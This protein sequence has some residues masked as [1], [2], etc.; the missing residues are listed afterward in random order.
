MIRVEQEPEPEGFDKTVRLPG[1]AALAAGTAQLPSH[2]RKC[3]PE[4]LAAYNRVCAYSCFFIPRVVGGPSVEHFAPKSR[5]RARAYE[6]SNYR[7]VCALMNSRKNSF[8]DVLDPFEI[9][10]GWFEL[11][12]LFFQVRPADGLDAQL[13]QAI[14]ETIDRLKLNDEECCQ[15]RIDWF[16]D[17]KLEGFSSGYMQRHAPFLFREAVRQGHRPT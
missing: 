10:D 13:T 7:L 1:A 11:E 6:W 14:D 2:W 3:I 16:E 8:E 5:S 12:F 9:E 17:W 4:L 15:A